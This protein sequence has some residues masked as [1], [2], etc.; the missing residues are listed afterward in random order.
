MDSELIYGKRTKSDKQKFYSKINGKILI[1]E[2]WGLKRSDEIKIEFIND[3]LKKI[4]PNGKIISPQKQSK[5][6]TYFPFNIDGLEFWFTIKNFKPYTAGGHNNKDI[7]YDDEY[8]RTDTNTTRFADAPWTNEL[9]GKKTFVI[10]IDRPTDSDG[11]YFEKNRLFSITNTSSMMYSSGKPNKNKTKEQGKTAYLRQWEYIHIIDNG[12]MFKQNRTRSA[13]WGKEIYSV[14]LKEDQISD[15]AEDIQGFIQSGNN[16]K[17]DSNDYRDKLKNALGEKYIRS[18][19]K[20]RNPRIQSAFRNAL[21]REIE[22]MDQSKID[23]LGLYDDIDDEYPIGVTIA[24]HIIPYSFDHLDSIGAANN[25]NG[26]LIPSPYDALF[27]KGLITFDYRSGKLI[28]SKW[29]E[30]QSIYRTMSLDSIKIKEEYMVDERKF[31]L[32]KH[33]EMFQINRYN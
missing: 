23:M 3:F 26:L 2:A 27:D 5:V 6:N 16:V 25:Y 4:F 9:K 15:Y 31:Y 29:I 20:K 18:E 11:N 19:T 10:A 1:N 28:P 8:Y 14:F 22:L 17:Y 7:D 13:H 24:S 32:K 33:N 30:R 12:F 21:K